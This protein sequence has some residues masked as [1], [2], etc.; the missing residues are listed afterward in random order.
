MAVVVVVAAAAEVV[1]EVV[2]LVTGTVMD[3]LLRVADW[4]SG[5][6]R[7]DGRGEIGSEGSE[8]Y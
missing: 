6:R 5:D 7:G 1:M 2:E 4:G 3:G 8:R